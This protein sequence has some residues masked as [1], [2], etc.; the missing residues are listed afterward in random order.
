M[1]SCPRI[2]SRDYNRGA[3]SSDTPP[4]VDRYG[5]YL[6]WHALLV[7]AGQ[8]LKIRPLYTHAWR[9][10]PWTDFLE[11]TQLSRQDGFWLSDLTDFVPVEMRYALAM[12]KINERENRLEDRNLLMP[13]LSLQ[14]GTLRLDDLVVSGHLSLPDDVD[15]SVG[16][17]LCDPADA[18]ALAFATITAKPFFRWLPNDTND[19]EVRV[20]Q[21]SVNVRPWLKHIEHDEKHLDRHDPY[22]AP[23]ALRREAPDE[24][25]QAFLRVSQRDVAGRFWDG[26]EPAAFRAEAWGQRGGRGEHSGTRV[27]TAFAVGHLSLRICYVGRKRPWW[28]WSRRDSIFDTA[29]RT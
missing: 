22:A 13:L 24:W 23:T 18:V 19:L 26:A 4:D 17:L 1:D 3:W 14:T 21:L 5:G 8:L 11:H 7:V 15:V 25:V 2:S 27:V 6:G 16:T 9:E 29:N 12:P 10:N 20:R 28:V